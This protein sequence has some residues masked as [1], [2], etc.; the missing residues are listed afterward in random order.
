MKKEK[1]YLHLEQLLLQTIIEAFEGLDIPQ[2]EKCLVRRCRVKRNK[3]ST[4]SLNMFDL[5]RK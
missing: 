5:I 1:K 2:D 3:D 4:L